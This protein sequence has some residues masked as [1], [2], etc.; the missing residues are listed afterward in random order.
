MWEIER[1]LSITAVRVHIYQK[2]S[3]I[4]GE[5]VYLMS[6]LYLASPSARKCESHGGRRAECLIKIIS[7]MDGLVDGR[8]VIFLIL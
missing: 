6:N 8:F 4:S 5:D 1:A 3:Y 7:I 2:I